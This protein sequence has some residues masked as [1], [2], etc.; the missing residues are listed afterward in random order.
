[1]TNRQNKMALAAMF[2]KGFGVPK[3]D[4]FK[5]AKKVAIDHSDT[6]PDLILGLPDHPSFTL[7]QDATRC[8]CCDLYHGTITFHCRDG[9]DRSFGMD[10]FFRA[11]ASDDGK[12]LIKCR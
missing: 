5:M 7:Q 1:M 9:K 3:K 10:L 4:A 6:I 11:H 8:S 2:H 12:R